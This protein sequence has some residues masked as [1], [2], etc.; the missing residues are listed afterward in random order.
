MSNDILKEAEARLIVNDMASAVQDATGLPVTICE[1]GEW[2]G[3]GADEFIA[4]FPDVTILR[5][6]T[7]EGWDAKF[8][9]VVLPQRDESGIWEGVINVCPGFHCWPEK[10]EAYYFEGIPDR[11]TVSEC[12]VEFMTAMHYRAKKEKFYEWL[13]DGIKR[14]AAPEEK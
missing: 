10:N 9:F 8:F 11:D 14:Q 13:A 5:R 6:F 4:K 7:M 3:S 12:I 2:E 1:M